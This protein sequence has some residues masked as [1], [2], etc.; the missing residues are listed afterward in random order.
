MVVVEPKAKR[1]YKKKG[2]REG[3]NLRRITHHREGHDKKQIT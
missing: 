1:K 2:K 3:R